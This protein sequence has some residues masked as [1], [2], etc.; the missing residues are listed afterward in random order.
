[1]SDGSS[2]SLDLPVSRIVS[3]EE[4]PVDSRR[5]VMMQMA[6]EHACPRCGVLVG[7]KS[8]EVRESRIKAL[9]FGHRP[10]SAPHPS[11]EVRTEPATYL[12]H[13]LS[14]WARSTRYEGGSDAL[15]CQ[16]ADGCLSSEPAPC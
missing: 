12:G 3:C 15:R 9:P 16:S 14:S 6:D 2:L 8:Y 5:V 7:G 10:R 1:M 13:N 11:T 4:I